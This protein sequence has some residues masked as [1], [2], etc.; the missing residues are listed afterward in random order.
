VVE[1][2]IANENNYMP[3]ILKIVSLA[4]LLNLA[5]GCVYYREHIVR[6]PPPQPAPSPAATRPSSEPWVSVD[7]TA[8]ERQVIRDYVIAHSPDG[9]A[10]KKG[11]PLPPGLAKKVARGGTL[12]PGWPKKL[13]KGEIMSAEVYRQCDPLPNEVVLRLPPQ[14]SGTILVAIEGKVVRLLRATLEILDVFDVRP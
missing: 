11:K 9:G 12:P 2:I 5:A 3:T 10:G 13:V 7:I 1:L 14:P 6:H 8:Q 4:A